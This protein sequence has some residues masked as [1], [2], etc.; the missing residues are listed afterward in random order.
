MVWLKVCLLLGLQHI[1][2]LTGFT[3]IQMHRLI[4]KHKMLYLHMNLTQTSKSQIWAFVCLS[5][6][7]NGKRLKFDASVT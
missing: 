5:L 3:Y 2:T 1:Q 6:E 4:Q 7:R